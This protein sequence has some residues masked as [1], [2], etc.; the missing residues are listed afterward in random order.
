MKMFAK[1]EI[2]PSLKER[3]EKEKHNVRIDVQK[4]NHLIQQLSLIDL[5]LEDLAVA[6]TL[7]PLIRENIEKIYNPIYHNPF[8]GTRSVVD[9]TPIGIDLS[10]SQQYVISFFDGI[11]DDKYADKRYQL[12]KYY[13]MTGVEV[14]WYLCTNQSFTNN[15]QDL[16]AEEFKDDTE[17]FALATKV[18]SKIFNLEVQLCL[19]AL[20]ML[21]NEAAATK[22][23]EAKMHVKE[24][25]GTITE[26]LAAMSE[27]MGAS[28][29]DVIDRSENIKTSI[30]EGL[31]S[32][33]IST[34]TSVTGRSQLDQAIEQTVSLKDSV[35]EIQ[36]SIR[37]LEVNSKEIGDIVAVITSIADQTNLLALNAAIEAARAGEHGKGF[38]VVAAEV[39]KLA[40]QTKNSSSNITELVVSTT[41][42]IE[43]VVE[44][45][46]DVNAK[47]VL[48]NQ[49]VQDTAESFDKILTASTASKE[50]NERNSEEMIKFT[51]ILKDIGEAGSKVADLADTLHETMQGY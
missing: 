9:M 48:A 1:R 41:R 39:R 29:T 34:E 15:I 43:N 40:E 16:L 50:Q 10:G 36:T 25:I 32:S 33:I 14:R 45:I 31:Q 23:T 5:T 28:V 24:S 6:K 47:T 30:E 42:Q 49:N 51:D 22:E 8:P 44:Q 21:Q 27:E 3:A 19:S 18:T 26:E 37:A 12:S 20:Q 46:D 17:S 7:Q 4:N 35:T 38:S 13:L 11:I 2:A